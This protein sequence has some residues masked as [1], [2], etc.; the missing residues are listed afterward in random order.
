MTRANGSGQ[1]GLIVGGLVLA[2]AGAGG[3]A[4]YFL[5]PG[6]ASASGPPAVPAPRVE[7]PPSDGE[8][9]ALRAPV[10]AAAEKLIAQPVKVT[11]DDKSIDTTWKDLGVV[12]DEEDVARVAARQEAAGAKGDTPRPQPV[13]LDRVKAL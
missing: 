3:L 13:T 1:L 9:M 10:R 7:P 2:L 4:A 8:G 6:E 5:S 12:L 11:F